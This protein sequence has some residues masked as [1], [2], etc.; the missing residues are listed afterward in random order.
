MTWEEASVV[1]CPIDRHR[2]VVP[3]RH[4]ELIGQQRDAAEDGGGVTDLAAVL[5]A[6]VP[7]GPRRALR[8]RTDDAARWLIIGGHVSVRSLPAGAFSAF[9]EWLGESLLLLP[10]TGLVAVDGAFA[11][12]LDP[13]RLPAVEAP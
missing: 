8:V 13:A 10:F 6:P 1:V 3:A 4:V 9:P 11:F 5:G 2:I 7:S 12:E